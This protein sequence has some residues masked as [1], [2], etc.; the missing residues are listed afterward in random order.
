MDNTSLLLSGFTNRGHPTLPA[1]PASGSFQE[2]S[3]TSLGMGR[4]PAA[5][6]RQTATGRGQVR[7]STPAYGETMSVQGIPGCGGA[8]RAAARSY[9]SAPT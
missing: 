2:L 6:C 9:L 3:R 4:L 7:L 1:L 5:Q 8:G